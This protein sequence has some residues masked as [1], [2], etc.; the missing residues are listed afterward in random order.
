MPAKPVSIAVLSKSHTI[1]QNQETSEITVEIRDKFGSIVTSFIGT[2]TL[3]LKGSAI[4][5]LVK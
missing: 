1:S 4:F 3:K 2:I 5:S